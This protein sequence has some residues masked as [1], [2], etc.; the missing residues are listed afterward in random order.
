MIFIDLFTNMTT[1]EI[2]ANIISAIGMMF[3]STS[4]LFKDKKGILIFQS[5]GQILCGVAFI[6]LQAYSGACVSLSVLII[7]CFAIFNKQNKGLNVFFI[8]III[9]LGT[10]GIVV[11]NLTTQTSIPLYLNLISILPIISNVEYN[12]VVLHSKDSTLYIRIAF[13]IS[14]TLWIVYGYFYKNYSGVIFNIIA[15]IINLI[16]ALIN[17]KKLKEEINTKSEENNIETNK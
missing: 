8:I 16:S 7:N 3:I 2:V 6:M 13:L 10:I 4:T 14:C 12:I 9:A 1:I 5:V 15:I 17:R 11:D